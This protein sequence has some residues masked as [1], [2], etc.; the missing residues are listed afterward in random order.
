MGA[1]KEAAELLVNEL[2]G[3]RIAALSIYEILPRQAFEIAETDNDSHAGE[4]ETSLIL[5]LRPE[6]VKGRDKEQYPGFTKPILVRD[7]LKYWP[8]AVWGD[9]R[10]AD[11]HKGKKLFDLMVEG[12][13]DLVKRL[14]RMRG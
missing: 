10:K 9:P 7:K 11:S 12:F 13:S 4:L 6:L 3:I 14:E 5:Y 8:G 1:I 2:E